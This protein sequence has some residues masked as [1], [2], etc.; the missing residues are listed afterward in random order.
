MKAINLIIKPISILILVFSSLILFLSC[1]REEHF[2]SSKLLMLK[3]DY[4]TNEFEGGKETHY[5]IPT[6]AFT[7]T[8]QYIAPADFGNLRL[9]YK[10]VNKIIFEGTI[11]WMGRGEISIPENILPANQ[12]QY[13]E[14]EDFVT[15]KQGFENIFNPNQ[16]EYDYISIWASVQSLVKVREYLSSNPNATVKL[17]LYTPSVGIGNPEDWDWII[18][19]KD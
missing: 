13:V 19:I 9:I 1:E 14:T 12:F 4:L 15:P 16:T 18:F 7:I 10:E 2:E 6:H 3:V 5:P 11:H 8:T 17:F